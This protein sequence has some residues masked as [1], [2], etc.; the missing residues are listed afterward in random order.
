ML[1]PTL[2]VVIIG[3]NEGSR[4][5]RCLQSIGSLKGVTP[6][7]VIYVDSASTDAS[8]ENARAHHARVIALS[9]EG[10][11]AARGRN[12]GW[13][14]ARGEYVLFLDGDTIVNPEFPGTALDVLQSDPRIAVVWGHRRELRPE[15]SVYNR[16]LDLDWVYLPGF[17][18]YFGGDVIIRRSALAE[19]G[20]YDPDLIAGEE[21][22]L[23]RRLRAR[24]YLILHIDSPMTLH[25]LNITRF[26]QY[27]RRALRA[28]YAY[29]EISSRFSRSSDPMWRAESRRNL[30]RGAAWIT[31]GCIGVALTMLRSW[32]LFA[33]IAVPAVLSVRSAWRARY[34]APGRSL[35]LLLYGIHSHL[36][37]VPVFFGQLQYRR[38]RRSG[39]QRAIIEYKGETDASSG[40]SA[41]P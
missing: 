12:A 24:G 22:E 18:E 9:G 13:S 19:T 37:Q 2:S 33:W 15:S 7:E 32:G 5:T 23:G 29:A 38:S 1:A 21:P 17:T 8:P 10:Q 39:K 16:V 30:I 27:W 14:C 4:L 36:Q 20:G 25:D 35:L 34:K 6:L 11:T 31:W 3:R 26:R 41:I 28:G 40:V